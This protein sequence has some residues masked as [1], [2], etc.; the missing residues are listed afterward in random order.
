MTRS[1]RIGMVM[2]AMVAAGCSKTEYVPVEVQR[3]FAAA[4]DECRARV[5][6]DLP[7]VPDLPAGA[8]SATAV[9]A[10][11]ASAWLRARDAYGRV[12]DDYRVCQRHVHLR[13]KR[14]G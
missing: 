14:Q 13:A 11:W 4:P 2:F 8:T 10:H 12:R 9:N 1:C 5:P 3:S 6:D 7:R